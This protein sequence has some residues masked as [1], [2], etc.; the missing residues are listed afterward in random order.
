MEDPLASNKSET[1]PKI[2]SQNSK[3]TLVM[4]S[5]VSTTLCRK[6]KW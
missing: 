3:P 6:A 1:N 4:S 2:H 5:N